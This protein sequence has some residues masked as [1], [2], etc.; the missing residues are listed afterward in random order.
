M[1]KLHR[2]EEYKA[3]I[4]EVKQVHKAS[5]SNL[6]YMPQDILRYIELGKLEYE[7][8]NAGVFFFFDEGTYYRVCVYIEDNNE[9]NIPQC[10]KK[11]LI[12][13]VYRKSEKNEKLERFENNLDHIGFTLSGTTFQVEGCPEVLMQNC[14][15]LKQYIHSM[16]KKGFHCIKA[17]YS[18][19]KVIEDIITDSRVIKDYHLSHRTEQEKQMLDFGSYLCVLNKENQI[20]AASLSVING[21]TAQNEAMAIKEEYKMKGLAPLLTY[22]RSKWLCE[23]KVNLAQGWILTN[24]DASIRYHKSLGYQLTG[25]YANEWVL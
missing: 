24:N 20:C 7:V 3:L 8:N 5:F 6:Y 21:E 19:Y 14:L 23:N 25:K 15:N 18:L 12:R 13:N 4:K 17:D 2:I 1:E 22:H 16:E 11:M 10:S 9:F